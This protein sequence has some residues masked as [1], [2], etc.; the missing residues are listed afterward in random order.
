MAKRK[1]FT[2][3]EVLISITL[4][5]IILVALF[6]LVTLMQDSNDHLYKQLKKTK[7]VTQGT[8]VLYR[9]IISSDGNLTIIKDEFTRLC[10]Q[11]TANSLYALPRPKVCWLV[12]KEDNIL[13]RVEGLEY[14]LPL[15][16]EDR[17]EADT[18]VRNV[19]LFDVYHNK[20][21]VLV[22]LKEKE[23]E[24]ITFMAHGIRKPKSPEQK[25]ADA[26]ENQ[27]KSPEQNSVDTNENQQK[28]GEPLTPDAD[29]QPTVP[30]QV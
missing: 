7:K 26:K 24:P 30:N 8:E 28:E 1:A 19:E 11:S 12:M 6:S 10:I 9:D 25:S 22:V 15:K 29:I 20:D 16:Y 13:M 27:Q 3:L 4:M 23:K 5:G 2:L 18:V 17:V 21:K 14:S